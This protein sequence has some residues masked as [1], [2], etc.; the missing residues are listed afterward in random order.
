MASALSYVSKFKSFLILF[1]T[2]IL[3]LPLIILAPTKV[4]CGPGDCRL[5]GPVTA[6]NAGHQV[7]AQGFPGGRSSPGRSG[8]QVGGVLQRT[9]RGTPTLGPTVPRTQEPSQQ[10][11]NL[12][13][14]TDLATQ[15]THRLSLA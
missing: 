15:D 7:G 8:R 10:A 9:S 1:V 3:L 11:W 14:S 6:P 13:V 4:S 5:P 12:A 2:P